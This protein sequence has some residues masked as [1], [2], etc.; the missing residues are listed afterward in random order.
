MGN[1]KKTMG[2]SKQPSTNNTVRMST[3]PPPSNRSQLEA[4]PN[5]E[6]SGTM[7]RMRTRARASDVTHPAAFD[8]DA[9]DSALLRELQRPQRES[10]IEASPSRKRQRI[11]AD[12]L[13]A[14]IGSSIVVW[15]GF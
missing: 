13:V 3:P 10:T 12:R 9:V 15:N 8:V 2:E 14:S 7:R 4:K 6:S 11:N 1:S 5:A